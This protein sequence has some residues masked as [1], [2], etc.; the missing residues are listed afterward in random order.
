MLDV[1]IV[2]G[3][4]AGLSA[5]LVLGRCLRKVL[6][7]DSSNP[8]NSRSRAIHG[9]L[10]RDNIPPLEFLNLAKKD[11]LAYSNVSVRNIE[12]TNI[13]KRENYF[14]ALLADGSVMNS[15]RLLIATGVI[16]NKP[17][18]AG[19][20]DFY[21]IS[22]F[23]C[24]YCDGWEFRDL[25]LAVYGNGDHGFGVSLELINWS[26]NVTLCTDGPP[27]LSKEEKSEL[28]RNGI[29]LREERISH[30][31]GSHGSIETI[32]FHDGSPLLCSALFFTL[33]Q[34]QHSDLAQKL[35]C[36]FTEKGSV[37][38]D[39]YEATC[40]PGLYVAGDASGELQF[41]VVAAAEGARAAVAIN[42][43]IHQEDTR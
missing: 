8:R 38:T 1:I 33:G 30:L 41:V 19:F 16:D 23:H 26:Q 42:K 5:A 15:R 7:L 2:G 20:D 39:K 12:V 36:E 21:G 17:S 35:G 31:I 32:I 29:N 24:P 13:Q 10:T 4:P 18:I 28:E 22:I 43:S 9:F 6:L 34:Q 14:E 11:L 40:V 3:G 25:P 37:K 27:N